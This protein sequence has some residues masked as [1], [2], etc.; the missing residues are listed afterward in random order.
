MTA[1]ATVPTAGPRP[2]RMWHAVLR[3]HRVALIIWAVIFA[4]LSG[5]LL[6]AY[7]PG[8]SA[9]RADWRRKCGSH[10][11][12]W[13][14]A[15][16]SYHLAHAGVE[17]TIGAIPYVAAVWAGAALIGRELETGTAHLSWTQGVSPTRWLATTLAVPAALITA[18]STVLVLVHRLLFDAHK[19]PV[20][21][22]WWDDA[23]F[24]ANGPLAVALSLLGLAVGALAGLLLRRA[25]AAGGL[26]F[27][28]TALVDTALGTARPHLW[29]WATGHGTLATGYATPSNVLFGDKGAVTSTG[30]HIAD[31]GCGKSEKCLAAHDVTG[32]FSHY[33]P[34]SHF[35]PLQ[36]VET[37]IVLAV[38]AAATAAAFRLL[39]R[40][41]A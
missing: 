13:S 3:L 4:A 12:G 16:S 14:S 28:A 26:A 21:W 39:R 11:C 18:G 1:L 8:A 40:R 19:V 41:T 27:I 36:L 9:A 35:W 32:Y 38:T 29:P 22:N 31:P 2:A 30:A 37:G 15:I 10:G 33:H 23:T 5:V 7:G 25:L 17:V 20:T 24:T 34:A 6:W